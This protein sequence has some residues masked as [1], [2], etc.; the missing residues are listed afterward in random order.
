MRIAF[1]HPSWPGDEGTGA[2]HTATQ[3]V[4]SLAN[5]GHEVLVYCSESIPDSVEVE[6]DIE[7]EELPVSGFPYHSN[8]QLNRAI[9]EK[10]NEFSTFD[11]TNCYLPAGLPAMASDR[12]AAVWRRYC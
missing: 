3:I 7:L 8:T 9:R 4:T 11:V 5:R 10:K 2:T 12:S 1:I 6:P